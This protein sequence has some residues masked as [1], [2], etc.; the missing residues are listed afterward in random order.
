MSSHQEAKT[1]KRTVAQVRAQKEQRLQ[2]YERGKQLAE[3]VARVLDRYDNEASSLEE[4]VD[5]T[6]TIN[7]LLAKAIRAG[8]LL[9][10]QPFADTFPRILSFNLKA[11]IHVHLGQH[12]LAV[13]FYRQADELFIA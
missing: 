8:E 5:T 13:A 4:R 2:E 1:K 10:Y 7:A 12:T 3:D 11:R 6:S 9:Q